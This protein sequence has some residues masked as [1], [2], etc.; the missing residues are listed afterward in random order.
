MHDVAVFG[1]A[2]EDVRNDF[3]ECLGENALVNVFDGI[4]YIFFRGTYTTHHVPL[5]V[6]NRHFCSLFLSICLFYGAK[7]VK[8]WEKLSLCRKSLLNLQTYYVLKEQ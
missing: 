2:S 4:M 7:V 3:A 1:V 6:V 8:N 5:A